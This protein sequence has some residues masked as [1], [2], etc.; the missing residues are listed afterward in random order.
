MNK[1]TIVQ[2]L[3]LMSLSSFSRGAIAAIYVPF[4]IAGGLNLLEVNLVN[5]IY[6]ST[7]FICEIPTGAFA[8]IFGRKASFVVSCVL[9]SI[10]GIMYASS[11]TFW[12]FAS[13]EAVLA[14]GA[15]FASGAFKAWLVDKL[16]HHGYTEPLHKVFS[17]AQIFCLIAGII[18]AF[19][20]SQISDIYIQLPWMMMATSALITG[21]IAFFWIEEEYFVKKK[22][23]FKLGILAMK[24]TAVQSIEF[25]IKN[26]VVRFLLVVGIIQVFAVQ[27][28]NMQW[29]PY[30]L[31]YLKDKKTLGYIWASMMLGLTAGSFLANKFLTLIKDER[32]AL[33]MCQVLIAIGTIA[34]TLLPFP[35][36]LALFILHE[37][38]RG[39]FVP[40]KDKFL[41]DNIPSHA[42]ATISSFEA[43]SPHLGGMIGLVASGYVAN[44]FG[45]S[46]AWVMSGLVMLTT[47]LLFTRK[48]SG[49]DEYSRDS[50]C[51]VNLQTT[52]DTAT[53]ERSGPEMD[54]AS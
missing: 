41:Q 33:T 40:L 2:Y 13:S 49:R 25:G 18:S 26:K 20:G 30:F 52:D 27:A 23:S 43:I 35:L 37:I 50:K 21:V 6:F 3:T 14:I 1:R 4:L 11:K 53:P 15:T 45:I 51:A 48:K 16:Q 9:T 34:I 17:K 32:K 5:L 36:G 22:F 8:D 19:I 47:T 31:E 54:V 28:P 44:R 38:P 46:S 12:G 10:G 24:E 29:S 42:R 39:M 7:L